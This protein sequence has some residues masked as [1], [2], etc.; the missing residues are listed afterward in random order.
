MAAKARPPP[1]KS[2][3][4]SLK[5]VFLRRLRKSPAISIETVGSG[6][7]RKAD[8]SQT[9]L[10]SPSFVSL[11]PDSQVGLDKYTISSSI[12]N[13]FAT[14]TRKA[15]VNSR[16]R[17]S[18]LPATSL[19]QFNLHSAYLQQS[20]VPH[21]AIHE[22]TSPTFT[23]VVSREASIATLSA[24]S[25]AS[26]S[27][28]RL[29]ESRQTLLSRNTSK[30]SVAPS[31]MVNA[32]TSWA[33][34][35]HV[36]W[37]Q[38]PTTS[39]VSISDKASTTGDHFH[40][41]DPD[42]VRQVEHFKSFCILDTL[43]PGCPVVATSQELRYIF[44]IGEHFFLNSCE[45]E[46]ASMDIVTGQDAAGDPVTHLVLFTPLV[47]PSSGRSRFMLASLIDVTRFIHD[48]ASLP[49]LEKVASDC[50]TVESDLRTPLHDRGPSNWNSARYKLSAEDLLGGCV[51]P[52][53]REVLSLKR[54]TESPED[55]WL[56]LANEERSRTSS[57]RNTPRSAAQIKT[58]GTSRSSNA[59]HASTTSSA[60][61][62]VLDEF[63]GGLQELYSDFFLL[64][65]S[66]LD[67][68]YY[69]IC[70]VS[71]MIYEAKDYIHG[72]LSRT[73][74][75]GLVELSARLAQGSPFSLE[76]KW[77]TQGLNKRLY[78]SPLYGQNSITWICFLVD[79][80]VASL[81]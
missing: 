56:N 43:V 50:S 71:P 28:L 33:R 74:Q 7:L 36:S 49:D 66:P 12:P 48:A 37:L 69:E 30:R 23:S 59:S 65:K 61:D 13:R 81:W 42:G 21:R 54:P 58:G 80:R 26:T 63:I 78:C 32:D 34:R 41:D 6:I 39:S 29:Q 52:E 1:R 22:V 9:T 15:T 75:Q 40:T 47:I 46:G 57:A 79:H 55:I 14:P 67:D 68:T 44:E 5:D 60:V 10:S 53:D 64:G 76:V 20:S 16:D 17:Q 35:N 18:L 24:I 2:L 4:Q 19:S 70:N 51:L 8:P 77:G 27:T 3:K 62:E 45:C 72:H 73:G 25:S 11:F 31:S 38:S